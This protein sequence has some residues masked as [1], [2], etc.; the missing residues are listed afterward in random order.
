[1]LAELGHEVSAAAVARLLRGVAAVFVLD[2]ADAALAGAV[3]AADMRAALLPAV[4]DSQE[5][6][7]R[8]AK[9]LL[10]LVG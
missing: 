1:M 3:E 8:L 9:A 10:A 2:P 4:M 7:R 6:R 5:A